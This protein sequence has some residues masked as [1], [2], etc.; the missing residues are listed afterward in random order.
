MATSNFNTFKASTNNN[1]KDY[2]S[3]RGTYDGKD[4]PSSKNNSKMAVQKRTLLNNDSSVLAIDENSVAAQQT[5]NQFQQVHQHSLRQQSLPKYSSNV[6]YSE[7]DISELDLR[8]KGM[9]N[10]DFSKVSEVNEMMHEMA[11]P[12]S[13]HQSLDQYFLGGRYSDKAHVTSL[14]K[15]IL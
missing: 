2:P 8:S 7:H 11:S 14:S 13:Y 9:L 12:T 15:T 4:S 3:R 10:S 1:G 5:S 6:R